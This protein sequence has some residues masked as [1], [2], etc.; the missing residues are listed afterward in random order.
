[1]S[2]WGE[3]NDWDVMFGQEGF[4]SATFTS[5]WLGFWWCVTWA[6]T[7]KEINWALAS[8]WLM[9]N[10]IRTRLLIQPQISN[11]QAHQAPRQWSH[12][13]KTCRCACVCRPYPTPLPSWLPSTLSSLCGINM[14]GYKVIG[15]SSSLEWANWRHASRLDKRA[16]GSP[17]SWIRW[18]TGFICVAVHTMTEVEAKAPEVSYCSN[19]DIFD[20]VTLMRTILTTKSHLHLSITGIEFLSLNINF[21][22]YL[23]FKKA[24]T[25]TDGA[26]ETPACEEKVQGKPVSWWCRDGIPEGDFNREKNIF[27]VSLA[28]RVMKKWREKNQRCGIKCDTCIWHSSMQLDLSNLFPPSPNM[29]EGLTI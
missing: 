18:W 19:F 10:L 27:P 4:D 22:F 8:G 25:E 6:A 14:T 12:G 17:M 5:L 2:D 7:L 20:A 16:G 15:C 11:G 23:S 29:I 28:F 26:P 9:P 24:V 1:M 21:L 3:V 13:W